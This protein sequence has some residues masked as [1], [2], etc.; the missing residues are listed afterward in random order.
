MSNATITDVSADLHDAGWQT[1]ATRT[2]GTRA[3]VEYAQRGRKVWALVDTRTND[4]IGGTAVREIRAAEMVRE[5][6]YRKR[7]RAY[8]T[9]DA[10]ARKGTDWERH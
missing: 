2:R 6:E 9:V 7:V 4:V 8:R 5:S 3:V 10:D 1:V